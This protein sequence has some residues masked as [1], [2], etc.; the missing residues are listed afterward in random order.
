VKFGAYNQK[1]LEASE[2]Y[3]F[4]LRPSRSANKLRGVT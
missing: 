4:Y 3:S 2:G 1:T